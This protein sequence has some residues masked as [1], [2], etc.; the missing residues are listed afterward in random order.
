MPINFF[1]GR[2]CGLYIAL[3]VASGASA[4]LFTNVS[5]AAQ[6]NV[7]YG[8]LANY[9][10]VSAVDFNNDGFDDLTYA[11]DN[12]IRFF[13]NNGNGTFTEQSLMNL[14]GQYLSALQWI[15]Y[16][17][18]GDYDFWLTQQTGPWCLMRNDGNGQFVN[19]VE[20]A[21]LD[22]DYYGMQFGST[23]AD[24]NRD[25]LLDLYICL[26]HE[27]EMEGVDNSFLENKL[28]QNLGNGTF[29]NVSS[30]SGTC[31]GLKLSFQATFFDYNR[32]LWPDIYIANDKLTPNSLYKN[33]MDGTFTN[34]A[35]TTGTAIAPIEAMSTTIDDFNND[36][37]EDLFVS[38]TN[39]Q[40]NQL[41]R[42]NNGVSYQNITMSSGMPNM[43]QSWHGSFEDFNND[44]FRDLMMCQSIYPASKAATMYLQN[45][46]NST[47]A[48]NLGSSGLSQPGV[49]N[50]SG[51]P[52]DYN[53][54]GALD[55]F[56]PNTYPATF[57]LW[58]NNMPANKWVNIKLKGVVSNRDGIGS[59]VDLYADGV[60][61][62]FFTHCGEGY[63]SQASFTEHMGLGQS[64]TID[65]LVVS[66]PSGWQDKYYNLATNQKYTL[67]E[68]E[69]FQVSLN[70]T[71]LYQCA[72]SLFNV[73]ASLDSAYSYLWST[74]DSAALVQ[75]SE[76][77][78]Y[79]VKVTHPLG[80][81][82]FS[83]TLRIVNNRNS[84]VQF[85][86]SAPLCMG[87]NTGSISPVN[88]YS[89]AFAWQGGESVSALSNLASG[90]YPLSIFYGA[91]CIKDTVI[92][93]PEPLLYQPT[94]TTQHVSCFGLS[95][96]LLETDFTTS[97][98]AMLGVNGVDFSSDSIALSAGT[99]QLQFI[100]ALGC[101]FDT[102][103]VIEQPAPLELT[104]ADVSVPCFG[105][106]GAI[107]P[108]V[109]T[110][111]TGQ[112]SIWYTDAFGETLVG[113]PDSLAAGEYTITA[114]DEHNCKD[115]MSF[116]VSMPEM[117]QATLQYTYLE[118]GVEYFLNEIAG[119]TEPYGIHWFFED[120]WSEGVSFMTDHCDELTWMV[121]DANGC[122]TLGSMNCT[123]VNEFFRVPLRVS[124]FGEDELLIS[125]S[126]TGPKRI[127]VLDMAGR[128]V[129]E[130]SEVS[131]N[132]TLEVTELPAGAYVVELLQNNL[133]QATKIVKTL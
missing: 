124:W 50:F 108:P 30:I 24:Y 59:W 34:V 53:N 88:Q 92:F 55:F 73:Y 131:S 67:N 96:G 107:Q 47:F 8:S 116:V 91:T 9:A 7:L 17:N 16:D 93:I 76:P 41:L 56:V 71:Q 89:A 13:Q 49:V 2:V 23:W 10:G 110:G 132:F 45:N 112:Y 94:I 72:D 32:D 130:T 21:G 12:T 36:G 75:L 18:D 97:Q 20:E 114:L 48:L 35:A 98:T 1:S 25:G 46:G 109:V 120:S 83:D 51:V 70:E 60:K 82:A 57:S 28:F 54:D 111:G 43:I 22:M 27:E 29:A 33:N 68:G 103:I 39:F 37:Y 42:N 65:S 119:G 129:Y 69:T 63:L 19:A 101:L 86:V 4:Q 66:W 118:S 106:L 61:R 38:G 85:A 113:I 74:G 80:F 100:S 31:D 125:T 64:A 58:K 6:L 122:T 78:E 26:Y 105:D 90:Y 11:V 15:D 87:E 14:S 115:S 126:L 128:T 52:I 127:E 117:I 62:S 102:T 40:M 44:G 81:H 123:E 77:G 79:F 95:D 5:Q 133:I 121:T 84:G 3:L 99:Y 104:A